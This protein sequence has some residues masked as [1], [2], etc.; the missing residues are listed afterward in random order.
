MLVTKYNREARTHGEPFEVDTV[1]YS[2]KMDKRVQ[3][4]RCLG[5]TTF[6]ESINAGDYY[7]APK[8]LWRV[9]VCPSCAEAIW[10]EDLDRHNE[11][12]QEHG[13]TAK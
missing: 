8:G 3:C 11:Q 5:Y 10:K 6:G 9:C 13:E 7:S 12:L 4:P 2:A 1:C